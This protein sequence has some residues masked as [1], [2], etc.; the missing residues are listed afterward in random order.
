M[1]SGTGVITKLFDS[2]HPIMGLNIPSQM[3]QGRMNPEQPGVTIPAPPD[4]V[5]VI[6]EITDDATGF[7]VECAFGDDVT[8]AKNYTVGQAFLLTLAA[9]PP[10]KATATITPAAA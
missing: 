5:I 1:I 8:N 9:P 3:I 7:K 4:R 6:V 10:A 2:T